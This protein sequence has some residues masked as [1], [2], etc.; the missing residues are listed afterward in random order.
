MLVLVGCGIHRQQIKTSVEDK[1]AL[2]LETEEEPEKMLGNGWVEITSQAQMITQGKQQAREEAIKQARTK[3][4]AVEAGIE[5]RSH[6]FDQQV[7]ISIRDNIFRGYEAFSSLSSLQSYGRVDEED[8]LSEE[9]VLHDNQ[10]YYKIRLKCH[11]SMEKGERDPQFF[12]QIMLNQQSFRDGEEMIITLEATKD[13]YCTIFNLLPD[14]TT[15]LLYPNPDV[16]YDM[17]LANIPFEVPSKELRNKGIH[18]RKY[19]D[20]DIPQVETL[21]VVATKTPVE[22]MEA[23]VIEDGVIQYQTTAFLAIQKWLLGIPLDERVEDMIEYL[24]VP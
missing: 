19:V 20:G 23:E 4:I 22:F 24:V 17:I 10:P 3:A 5:I 16:P 9:V 8:I 21:Y 7:E 6:T 12:L 18:L 13:C 11:V 2:V 15:E 1:S 14:N